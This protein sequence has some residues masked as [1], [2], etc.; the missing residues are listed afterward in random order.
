MD[1]RQRRQAQPLHSRGRGHH[2]RGGAI[3]D[4][5]AVGRGDDA[6]L[7]E[8]R[9]QR[10]HFRQIRIETDAFIHGQALCALRPGDGHR[11]DLG[12]KMAGAGGSRSLDMAVVAESVEFGAGQPQQSAIISAERPCGIRS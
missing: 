2:H 11:H 3:A 8:G 9:G 7:V 6:V 10:G 4:L 12:L 1:P 5:A